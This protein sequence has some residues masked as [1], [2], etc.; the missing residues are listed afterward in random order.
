MAASAMQDVQG[1]DISVEG[2]TDEGSHVSCNR[3][4]NLSLI[5]QVRIGISSSQSE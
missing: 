3:S 5:E 1:D 4:N 2:E